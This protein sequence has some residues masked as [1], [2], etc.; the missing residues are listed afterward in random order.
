MLIVSKHV[1]NFLDDCINQK[2]AEAM[3]V[4]YVADGTDLEA[5]SSLSEQRSFEQTFYNNQTSDAPER[6]DVGK[7]T[8]TFKTR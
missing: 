3:C 5:V 4:C 6:T 8:G 2:K 1:E 7:M